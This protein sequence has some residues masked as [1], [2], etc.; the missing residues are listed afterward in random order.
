MLTYAV[1]VL[2]VAVA[3]LLAKH[4]LRVTARDRDASRS[5]QMRTI[6][7]W[8]RPGHRSRIATGTP[9]FGELGGR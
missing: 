9:R 8:N 2:C 7:D 1:T 4:W 5:R 6:L 3:L